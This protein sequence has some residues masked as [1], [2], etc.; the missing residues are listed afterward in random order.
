[1]SRGVA[2]GVPAYRTER[3]GRIGRSRPWRDRVDRRSR[4]HQVSI[5]AGLPLPGGT[6]DLVLL[7]LIGIAL[8]RGPQTGALAGFGAG[9]V[10]D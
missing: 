9:L 10:V 3:H 1:M 2:S 6:A 7:V 5:L 8:A 4:G